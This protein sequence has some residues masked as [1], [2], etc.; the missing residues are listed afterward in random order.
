MTPLADPPLFKKIKCL[1]RGGFAQTFL[2]QVLDPDRVKDWGELVA[3]KNPLSDNE[4][5]VLINELILNASL[6]K[7]LRKFEHPNIVRYLGFEKFGSD[8]PRD[9]RWS[10]VMEYVSGGSLRDRLGR[11]GMQKPLDPPL[12]VEIACGILEGLT[13]IHN[14]NLI[15][16]DIKPE[17]ILMDGDIP[18]IAD[19]GLGRMLEKSDMAYS[20]YGTEDYVPPEIVARS[21]ASYNAD[22][23]SLGVTFF[24]LLT[25]EL[26]FSG[27]GMPTTVVVDN[28]RY[29][30]APSPHCINPAVPQ[31][32]GEL[33]IHALNKDPQK[34]FA[35]AGEM[36]AA[37]R[38]LGLGSGKEIERELEYVRELMASPDQMNEA[39]AK[40]QELME[41]YPND[42]RVFQCHGE[43]HNR[44]QKH[45]NA[46]KA[47]KQCIELDPDNAIYHWDLALVLQKRGLI[48]PAAAELKKAL[49]LG[50][51]P[52]L[53]R[54]AKTLLS[55]LER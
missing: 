8:D 9:Q 41:S 48:K 30:E 33:V 54:Y 50:L 36:L 5:R 18:K 14:V 6:H 32:L 25:G 39:S 1:G 47:F 10:M 53:Q 27:A 52:S 3:I 37:L 45:A 35:D 12:A 38:N 28:I 49:V 51:E 7:S 13:A 2:V 21:G 42:A 55:T 44:R 43:L 11:R 26:P 23:W 17:N 19:L 4:E 46:I 29:H 20:Q 15:H 16:R 34:R 24:E 31:E 22:I 40:L